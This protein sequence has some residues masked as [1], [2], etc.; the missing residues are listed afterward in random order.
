MHEERDFSYAT[1][2]RRWEEEHW[3][4]TAIDFSVD[5]EH[6]RTRLSDHQRSTALWNY[7]MFLAGVE[8][9]TRAVP[10]MLDAAR[11]DDER[12]LFATHAVDAARHRVFLDRWL[13]EVAGQGEDSRSTLEA[14]QGHLTWGF[15]QILGELDRAA[16]ALR[17]QPSERPLFAATIALCHIV[18]E[19]VLAVPGGFFI[20]RYLE[21]ENLLPG[22]ASGLERS[23]RD[24]AR[25][26]TF[27]QTLLAHL[28]R[29]S[30]DCRA[31]AVSTWNRILSPMVGVFLPPDRDASYVEAFGTTMLEVYAFGLKTFESKIKR[32]GVDP[33]ELFL[34]ARDDRSLTYEERARR[35]LVLIDAGVLG[36]DT[37]EPEVT[38]EALEILFGAT[39]RAIDLNVARTLEGPVEWD[40]TD[41]DPWHLVLVDDGVE[42]K[43][44]RAGH[45]ALRLELSA[46]DWARIAVGRFDPRW[47]LLRRRLRVHGTLAAKAKLSKLFK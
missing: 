14:A 24:A 29:S 40:F 4:A 9:Q 15:R 6:W 18:I 41:A 45:A 19:G 16:E 10:A 25:H 30:H 28:I 7:A 27:G 11:H 2:Y 23:Q 38:S 37:Q 46:A 21:Q 43:P 47:A 36:N 31:A 42:A 5:A 20:N 32:V 35:L 3:S 13:R 22:L 17:R 1:L 34:L 8:A 12:T 33:E 39:V 44:G 26:V